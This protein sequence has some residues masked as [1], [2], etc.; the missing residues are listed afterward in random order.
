MDSFFGIGSAEL[1][2]ILIL[3]GIVL[4]PR[5]IRQVAKQLGYWSA[6]FQQIYKAFMA[7]INNELDAL[8]DDELRTTIQEMKQ[9]GQELKQAQS[10]VLKTSNEVFNEGKNTIDLAQNGTPSSSPA[11]P[12]NITPPKPIEID[13]DPAL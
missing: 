1:I 13:G 9:F 2:L 11:T 4:G 6:R 12:N 8:D 10:E 5:Q 3:A 7:Q